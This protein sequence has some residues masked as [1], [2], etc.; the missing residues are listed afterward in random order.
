MG[1]ERV[2]LAFV[3]LCG[4]QLASG[5]YVIKKDKIGFYEAHSQIQAK[6]KT[7]TD[8]RFAP[9]FPAK[10]SIQGCCVLEHSDVLALYVSSL[11][12]CAKEVERSEMLKDYQ[13][14]PN[15]QKSIT[16]RPTAKIVTN[17]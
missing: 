2:A 3:L 16:S 7:C 15:D 10:A 9:P 4:L 8:K 6:A 17:V 1:L 5:A 14:L 11:D 13:V 12:Y